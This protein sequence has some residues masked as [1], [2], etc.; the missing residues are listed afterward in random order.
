[1]SSCGYAPPVNEKEH[2]N[3]PTYS[4]C[5]GVMIT[6][7]PEHRRKNNWKMHSITALRNVAK[8]VCT[9]INIWDHA[10]TSWVMPTPDKKIWLIRKVNTAKMSKVSERGGLVWRIQIGFVS[11]TRMGPSHGI[12]HQSCTTKNGS[13]NDLGTRHFVVE[14]DVR[15]FFKRTW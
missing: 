5:Q 1:M 2:S 8:Q 4:I 9:S 6:G 14:C 3:Y 15:W 13:C 10:Y 11:M 7:K 12:P